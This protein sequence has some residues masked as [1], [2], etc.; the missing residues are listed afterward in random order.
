MAKK[1]L[2]G[3]VKIDS[4]AGPSEIAIIADEK[5]SPTFI[6]ADMMSQAEHGTG[7]EASTAFVLSEKQAEEIRAE[8]IRLTKENNLISA[9]EKTFTNYGDIFVVDSIN[10]AVNAV[11]KI[12]P[13]HVEVLLK[14]PDEVLLISIL[15]QGDGEFQSFDL[16][17]D[18]HQS[19]S[20]AL[21]EMEALLFLTS[22]G[23]VGC[24]V[25][26]QI[27]QFL[28]HHIAH[29]TDAA[30]TVVMIDIAVDTILVDVL[31]EQLTDDGKDL[32]TAGVIGEAPRICH[33]T[34]ID[35]YCKLLTYLGEAS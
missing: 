28:V 22:E 6:A 25:L 20:I 5:A 23:V 8:I 4:I 13:E 14:N 34:T 30:L 19:L 26:G 15:T 2:F 27:N 35:G 18:V 31:C 16:L 21:D 9:T 24:M 1:L 7:F 3:E 17:R 33:H 11:N 32:W 29:Q 10:D 12:A